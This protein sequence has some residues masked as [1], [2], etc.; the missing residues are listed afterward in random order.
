MFKF[1]ADGPPMRDWRAADRRAVG[2]A[3]VAVRPRAKRAAGQVQ[4]GLRT[5]A[6]AAHEVQ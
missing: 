1:H 6:V 5:R 4:T 2:I 3:Q